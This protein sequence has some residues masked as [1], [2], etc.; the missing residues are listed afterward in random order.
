MC[1]QIDPGRDQPNQIGLP[2]G[3]GVSDR[4][5]S[6]AGYGNVF[7]PSIFG[8]PEGAALIAIALPPSANT[9]HS[10]IGNLGFRI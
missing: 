6:P 2:F 3:H 7:A 9:V 10:G 1:L 4:M 8:N 5:A